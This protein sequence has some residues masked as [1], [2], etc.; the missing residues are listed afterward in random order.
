MKIYEVKAKVFGTEISDVVYATSE[1]RAIK[2]FCFMY[3]ISSL[4]F[5][6]IAHEYKTSIQDC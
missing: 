5:N 3:T 6:V 2:K 1:S 4:E